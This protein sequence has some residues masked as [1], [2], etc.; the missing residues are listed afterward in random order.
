MSRWVKRQ[1][2]QYK[3][4]KD[5]ERSTLTAE[6][7]KA[8]EDIGFIWDSHA[9]VWDENWNKLKEY[10][11]RNG[12]CDVPCCYPPDQKLATWVKAQRRQYVL[13]MQNKPSNMTLGRIV[14]LDH[15]G[16]NWKR[17]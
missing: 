14:S 12:D 6:R 17:V 16:F 3:L 7:E 9:S 13:F 11:G 1:R 2:Y 10:K 15:L 4:R 8:L 5:G